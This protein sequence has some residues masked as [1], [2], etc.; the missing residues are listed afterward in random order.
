[1]WNLIY[2]DGYAGIQGLACSDN[3]WKGG[4]VI[5]DKLEFDKEEKNQSYLKH[6]I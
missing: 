3:Y 5:F 1:M 4:G 6:I 2:C